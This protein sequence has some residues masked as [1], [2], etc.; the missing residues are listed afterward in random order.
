MP[1]SALPPTPASSTDI[2]GQDGSKHLAALQTSFE[3]PPPALA[4]ASGDASSPAA[5][6]TD[7]TVHPSADMEKMSP[8]VV[9]EYPVQAAEA[10][11]SRR[12]SAAAAAAKNA[13]ALPPPP[14]RSRKII[15]MKPRSASITGGVG[16]SAVPPE[17][18]RAAETSSSAAT[19]TGAGAAATPT[20]ASTAT[21]A[22]AATVTA[23]T[24]VTTSATAAANKRKPPSS[25]S[26]AGRK[27][28]R[29]T[30]HS[31]IERR[32]RSK[33]NEEFAVLK[34]MI[35]ACTGEMHKLAILQASIEY[36]RY[37]EDCV[38][39]L[40][41]HH[42]GGK[43]QQQQQLH[44]S[45][46]PVRSQYDPAHHYPTASKEE[47]TSPDVEMD[48]AIGQDA[49]YD[50]GLEGDDGDDVDVNLS[51]PTWDA[52]QP[53]SSH[54]T[55]HQPS[56]S[57]VLLAQDAQRR[58]QRQDS[59]SSTASVSAAAAAAE[60]AAIEHHR[61]YSCS[62][63]TQ[64][65]PA[66]GPQ[67]SY[68][69]SATTASVAGLTLTSPALLPQRD[70]DQE[71]T[72]A[73]LMLNS[74]RR[75]SVVSNGN[76]AS[77]RASVSDV[78]R[79]STVL[80]DLSSYQDVFSLD[81]QVKS[82]VEDESMFGTVEGQ[83]N[84]DFAKPDVVKLIIRVAVVLT[85]KF[86]NPTTRRSRESMEAAERMGKVIA[87]V[88]MTAADL[89]NET[90]TA[91][92][93]FCAYAVTRAAVISVSVRDSSVPP[94]T[95]HAV[96]NAALQADY[97]RHCFKTDSS[98]CGEGRG[99]FGTFGGRHDRCGSKGRGDDRP[100]HFP[101]RLET[102]TVATMTVTETVT[103]TTA[104]AANGR[105]V[106]DFTNVVENVRILRKERLGNDNIR[107]IRAETKL[108][109]D[110]STGILDAEFAKMLI[111]TEHHGY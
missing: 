66:F 1:P 59:L 47:S 81:Q 17:E 10:V 68:L 92:A 11:K 90:P 79:N 107:Q 94:I 48:D 62:A 95:A 45:S 50:D 77:S 8:P 13:F 42:E 110:I 67:P 96:G 15:Q 22:A 76:N 89:T 27:I 49:A 39:S 100:V 54:S 111:N 91:S 36:V 109:E 37:L 24:A 85:A 3:L 63:S 33:M 69:Y 52:T 19:V 102:V 97:L 70:L 35:P 31:L 57:P 74:D 12:R 4:A 46:S 78:S 71:A 9:P 87:A 61:H 32:R 58:P 26:A 5:S 2:K 18:L 29:K 105:A 82:I 88:A 21:A 14:T 108:N 16:I 44:T 65:S 34:N 30:A 53:S 51:S 75:G 38:A 28:A 104:A 25:T 80:D 20:T 6:P 64:A 84:L 23:T 83:I 43:Q 86:A 40:K 72:A 99:I 41:A 98:R 93:F 60:A 101:D 7:A 106:Q 56:V 73:L 103:V 55:V